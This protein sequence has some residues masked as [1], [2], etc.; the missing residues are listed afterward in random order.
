MLIAIGPSLEVIYELVVRHDVDRSE[1]GNIRKVV[2]HTLDHRFAR[3][4]EQWLGSVERQWIKQGRITCGEND[5]VHKRERSAGKINERRGFHRVHD[6]ALHP[7]Q[8]PY[9]KAFLEHGDAV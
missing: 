6:S 9:L 4:L 8:R 5:D 3:D 7:T 1:S 2:Q